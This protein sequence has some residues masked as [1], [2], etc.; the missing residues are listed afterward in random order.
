MK[1]QE[2]LTSILNEFVTEEAKASRLSLE[3]T[4]TEA[5]EFVIDFY[6]LGG[7]TEEIDSLIGSTN[8]YFD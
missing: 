3:Q 6:G 2:R 5:V 4:V 1:P 8:H 7:D